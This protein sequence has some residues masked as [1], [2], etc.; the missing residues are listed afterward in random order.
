MLNNALAHFEGQI[1][2]GERGIFLLEGFNNAQGVQIVVEPIVMLPH[3]PVE[4]GLAGVA[5]RRVA[6]VMHQRQRL[7]QVGIQSQRLRHRAAD[8]RHFQGVGQAIAEVVGIS[9]GEN[10]GFVLQAA[11]SASVDNAVAVAFVVVAVRVRGL[12]VA[13]ALRLFHPHGVGRKLAAFVLDAWFLPSASPQANIAQ[14]RHGA[15]GRR[16]KSAGT[17][18]LI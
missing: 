9:P 12:R 1:E 14:R 6:D 16:V 17:G 10:L 2:A 3:Q 11:E 4:L 15:Q 13:P 8:L 7:H 18:G 5:A